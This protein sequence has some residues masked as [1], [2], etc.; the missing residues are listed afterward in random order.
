MFHFSN[1][2]IGFIFNLNSLTYSVKV[3]GYTL[4]L[5]G[6]VE[7]SILIGQSLHSKVCYFRVTDCVW[8]TVLTGSGGL[9]PVISTRR[10]KFGKCSTL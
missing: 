9:R 6:F 2:S 1:R 7:Y 5:H 3:I 4:L 8:G 10:V